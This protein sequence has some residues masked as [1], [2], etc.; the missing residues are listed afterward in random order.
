[1]HSLSQP[2]GQSRAILLMVLAIFCFTLMDASVKALVP[3]T[4][5]MTA[6]W[7]RYAGQMLAV[8]ILV[9]PRIT[10]VVRTRYPM[11]Q[12][13]RS[14]MLMGTTALFFTALSLIPL[15]D[16][17]ALMALNPVLIT[18]GA[19]LFLGESLGPRRIAGIA[20]ALVGA[21]IIIR[22]GSAVFS[23]A[24]TLPLAAAIS[25]S[26]YVLLT[27][28]LGAAE[29]PWTSLF[30]TGLVGTLVFSAVI[31]FFW[32]TPDLTGWL[33]VAST[34]SFGTL[35]QMFLIRSVSMGE[36]AMLAPYSYCGLIFATLW[37]TL[38]FDEIPD[39]WT[40][41]GALVIVSAGLYVWYRETILRR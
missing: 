11:Q 9:L 37:G 34:A 2:L 29:D 19:A 39:L 26:G 33:L 17:T 21:V 18:L 3:R 1:M 14:L 16:A 6:L 41:L 36:A 4:G 15:S 25:Y 24:A 30:Y 32:Q 35:G 10:T 31:P 22:P 28:K 5:V 23:T 38:L 7:A 12:V 13:A 27:R 40:L 8:L 20:V